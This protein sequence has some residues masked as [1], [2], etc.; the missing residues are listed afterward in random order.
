MSVIALANQ[1][2]GQ[3]K[4]TT[5]VN[6]GAALLEQGKTVLVIDLDPQAS[7]TTSLGVNPD[8]LELSLYDVFQA[9]LN[10]QETPKV[11]DII[12]KT[13]SGLDLA[14]ANLSLSAAELDLVTA[15]SGEFTLKEA[16]APIREKYDYTLIDCL[17]S[18]GLLTVNALAA[19]DEVLIPLQPEYLPM[20]GLRLL[21]RS[22]SKAQKKLNPQLKING[23][24]LTMVE[25]RTLHT[26]EVIESLRKV[27]K[28]E[29]RIYNSQIKRTVKIKE[30]AVAGESILTYDSHHEVANAYRELAKEV[31]GA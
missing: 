1:K 3:A 18:L 12:I 7:L 10:D 15:L 27:F 20:Q 24:L 19:T 8:E 2:G 14:P 22:I 5:T 4:T 13:K 17:P 23:I 6:L 11:A 9:I 16:L 30:S 29:V 26:R 21:L 28:D 31:Q 25:A